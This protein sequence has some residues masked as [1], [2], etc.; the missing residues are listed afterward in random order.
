MNLAPLQQT[1]KIEMTPTPLQQIAMNPAPLQQIEMTP[2]QA[3]LL[4]ST[5][6]AA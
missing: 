1:H 6:Q 4:A 5:H 2:A 3:T